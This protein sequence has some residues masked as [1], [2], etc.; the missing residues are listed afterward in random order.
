MAEFF[1]N[2][3]LEFVEDDKD[4]YLGMCNTVIQ[5]GKP[6]HS[7]YG[8]SYLHLKWGDAEFYSNIDD[9]EGTLQFEGM[10]THMSG[11]EI[12]EL[13]STGIDIT[14]N[15]FSK[16]EKIIMFRKTNKKGFIPIDIVTSDLIP[17]LLEGEKV[18]LQ[19][20]GFPIDIH[21]YSSEDEYIENQPENEYGKKFLIGDGGLFP[22]PFL[23]NHQVKGLDD[24]AYKKQNETLSDDITFFKGVVEGVYH[25]FIR[26]ETMEKP[27]ERAFIRCVINTEF[28]KL[29]LAHTLEQV[30]EKERINIRAG[31]VVYGTCVLS[32]D[33]NINVNENMVKSYDANLSL[34]RDALELGN[35]KRLR[36]FLTNGSIYSTV[37]AKEP[38]IGGDAI[39][40]RMELVDRIGTKCKTKYVVITSSLNEK[41]KCYT[42]KKAIALLY[43]D[44]IETILCL[45][46]DANDNIAM[47]EVVNESEFDYYVDE[48]I[49]N[50]SFDLPDHI[51]DIL[52]N[53]FR[54]IGIID[55]DTE[56]EII[57]SDAIL[58][59]IKDKADKLI[60]SLKQRHG[61]L[62]QKDIINMYS[63]FLCKGFDRAIHIEL[64]DKDYLPYFRGDDVKV[65]NIRDALPYK[66]KYLTDKM[67]EYGGILSSDMDIYIR[68]KT[69]N[70]EKGYDM[71][72]ESL[73]ATFEIG[74]HLYK[75]C[76]EKLSS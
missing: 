22:L 24:N 47:M 28:G 42:Q 75:K 35:S 61:D 43:D 72:L 49:D 71:I 3:G 58:T 29:E 59:T 19:I 30:D 50:P 18:R 34:I 54:A 14:P 10:N 53:K 13:E 70:Q 12:W 17:C 11:N 38:F 4:S 66:Y 39:V 1:R 9:K 46:N 37:N 69:I 21:Y 2:L 7:Y 20:A 45:E 16:H 76:K 52:L 60:Q 65:G 67:V 5:K 15:N 41:Y 8:D 25:G 40:E 32:G 31:S 6:I 57:M 63:Y 23:V 64:C 73:C 48:E 74:E 68:I 33:A 27:G 44:V 56:N 51:S 26:T 55:E 36:P 62:S